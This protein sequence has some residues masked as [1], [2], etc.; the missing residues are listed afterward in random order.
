[1]EENKTVAD[2]YK[3]LMD[4]FESF[5][6]SIM[7]GNKEVIKRLEE[8]TQSPMMIVC[9]LIKSKIKPCFKDGKIEPRAVKDLF[10]LD[11]STFEPTQIDK[12]NKFIAAFIDFAE[13]AVGC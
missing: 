1:M 3:E 11:I 2:V 13:E 7:M 8:L 10:K 9:V 12:L 6:R 5:V 4:K